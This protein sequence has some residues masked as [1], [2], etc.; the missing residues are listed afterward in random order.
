[1]DPRPGS[2]MSQHTEL[3]VPARTAAEV[4]RNYELGAD[5]RGLLNDGLSPGAF[6]EALRA[7]ALY[8]DA[9][10]FLAYALPK[11]EAVWWACLCLWHGCRPGPDAD[12]AAVL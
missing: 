10:Q 6:V 9:L 5:A 11:R 4:A 2:M 3:R 1:M 12:A 7:A 8:D